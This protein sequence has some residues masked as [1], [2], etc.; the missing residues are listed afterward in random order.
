VN[1]PIDGCVT[2]TEPAEVVG[3]D[4][5]LAEHLAAIE[6]TYAGAMAHIAAQAQA[7]TTAWLHAGAPG[8]NDD[9]AA[10]DRPTTG[11]LPTVTDRPSI[12]AARAA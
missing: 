4:Y 3:D 11:Q 1:L 9:G 5:G 2:A 12:P 8:Q 10:D 7:W 6:R